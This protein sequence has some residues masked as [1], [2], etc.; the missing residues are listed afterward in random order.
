EH[1]L[2]QLARGSNVSDLLTIGYVLVSIAA[3]I[4]ATLLS[5]SVPQLNL[6]LFFCALMICAI[7]GGACVFMG[8]R[9]RVS[10]KS[11]VE[12]IKSRMPSQSASAS[13]PGAPLPAPPAA[14]P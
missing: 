8:W 1:E 12:A 6:I 3:T 11:Q 4:L 14:V 7:A 9:M 13:A 2:D 5:T 10:V